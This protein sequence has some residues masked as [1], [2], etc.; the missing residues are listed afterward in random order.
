[1]RAVASAD[2]AVGRRQDREARVLEVV[3]GEL[4]D[5]RLVV[6]D[7]DGLGAWSSVASYAGEVAPAQAGRAG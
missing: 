2:G 4:D 5:P 3:A 6:D 7:E 1:M